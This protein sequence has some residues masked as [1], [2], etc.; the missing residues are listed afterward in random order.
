MSS[1]GKNELLR[2]KVVGD[3]DSADSAFKSRLGS[4]T[5]AEQNR[6]LKFKILTE[7]SFSTEDFTGRLFEKQRESRLKL[8]KLVEVL[9]K[10]EI[11]AKTLK[12]SFRNFSK[13][14]ESRPVKICHN[15]ENH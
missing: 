5:F 4:E 6:T 9:K 7:F 8:K 1:L 11:K 14:L 15:G 2:P 3:T 10:F 13:F 12:S